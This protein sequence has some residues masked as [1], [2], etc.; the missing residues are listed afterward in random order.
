M[1]TVPRS[2]GYT[3][4]SKRAWP[5]NQWFWSITVMGPACFR[6]RT[7]SRA[8]TLEQ[9]KADFQVA[10]DAF[11]DFQGVDERRGVADR[12]G[13][14]HCNSD[15]SHRSDDQLHDPLPNCDPRSHGR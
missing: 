1:K 2:A 7:D 12:T 11:K 14:Y 8:D 5:D 13:T 10:W 15:G 6:V 4:T 3:R 9:A